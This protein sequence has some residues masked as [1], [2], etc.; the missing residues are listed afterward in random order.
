MKAIT[1]LS[2][3]FLANVLVLSTLVG[4]AGVEGEGGYLWEAL[5]IL[6]P[7]AL[8]YQIRSVFSFFQIQRLKNS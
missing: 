8:G 3:M 4:L 5:C 6:S 2:H 1:V 7:L